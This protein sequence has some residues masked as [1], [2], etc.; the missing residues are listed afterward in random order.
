MLMPSL[1]NNISGSAILC[2]PC[3]DPSRGFTSD[4]PIVNTGLAFLLFLSNEV[5]LCLSWQDKVVFKGVAETSGPREA[6]M[7]ILHARKQAKEEVE[8]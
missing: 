7:N 1:I 4:S 6:T 2:H 5:K 3:Q 8:L